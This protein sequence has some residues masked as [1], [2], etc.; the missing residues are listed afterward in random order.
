MGYVIETG[1]FEEPGH[2]H[3]T[4]CDPKVARA[5]LRI[6]PEI[7]GWEPEYPGQT[8]DDMLNANI[9]YGFCNLGKDG[10]DILYTDLLTDCR[11]AE[12]EDRGTL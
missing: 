12:I 6:I 4:T 11:I 10:R 5:L 1:N 2:F 8:V 9:V 3:A 7:Q